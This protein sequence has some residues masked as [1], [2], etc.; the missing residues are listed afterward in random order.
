[1]SVPRK[2]LFATFVLFALLAGSAGS[3]GSWVVV[4]GSSAECPRGT[5]PGSV[6]TLKDRI[7][8]PAVTSG[9]RGATYHWLEREA[10]RV[11]TR[12]ADAVAIAD[13]TVDGELSTRL[14]DL[15][16][17]D[18]VAVSS[19][20]VDAQSDSLE[21]T[22]ADKPAGPDRAARHAA[23]RSGL[24]PTL[25]WSNEQAYSLWKDRDALDRSSLEWQDTLMRPAGA[26]GRN[27]GGTA[28]RTDTEWRGGL[29]ATVISKVGT[30]ISYVTGRQTTG[31]VFISSFRKDGNEVGSS[32]WWPQEQTLAW[33]FPGL[34]E[35]FVDAARL[36][37]SGG[38]PITPDMGWLNTQNLAFYRFHTL[39][40]ER[41]TISRSELGVAGKDWRRHHPDFA[42]KRARLRRS[43]LARSD[44]PSAVLRLTR[45][46]L[47][48][49]GPE[50]HGEQLVDVV[51]EL[52]VQ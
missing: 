11:T 5:T 24:R 29:S 3:L 16:G 6:Q 17:N 12:F 10:T 21:F 20:H 30:H 52:A 22:L 51:V 15:A 32:Q 35:G 39:V 42:R 19:A 2:R 31:I 8:P 7:P 46:L 27:P 9:D 13:R 40:K 50:L 1:M 36:R 14:T 43:A 34:T 25:D 33:S 23:R 47:Q 48:Q 26:P 49:A 4:A 28:L 37:Q 41:G 44:Y 38:W 18:K 45:L